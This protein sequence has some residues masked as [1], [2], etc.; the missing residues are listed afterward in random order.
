MSEASE[1]LRE[2]LPLFRAE[3]EE[4]LNSISASL[5]EVEDGPS[6]ERGELV[7]ALLREMHSLKGGARAVN[8]A[9]VEAISHSFETVLVRIQNGELEWSGEVI[10]ACHRTVEALAEL[11]ADDGETNGND[12]RGAADEIAAL[13]DSLDRP[14][15]AKPKKKKKKEKAPAPDL[16]APATEEEQE[17][18]KKLLPIFRSEAEERLESI[19]QALEELRGGA[20]SP[21]RQH[22]LS[23]SVMRDA[24]SIKGGSRTMKLAHVA[25]VC[26]RFEYAAAKLTR[27]EVEPYPELYDLFERA[28]DLVQ[29]LLE[30]PETLN[31]GQINKMIEDLDTI[32]QRA[33]EKVTTPAAPE[34]PVPPVQ[35]SGK[36]AV[37]ARS[38]DTV[39]VATEKLDSVLRHSQEML[40]AK[41]AMQQRNSEVGEIA[42]LLNE[43]QSEWSRV[44]TDVYRLQSWVEKHDEESDSSGVYALAANA[45]RFLDWNQKSIRSLQSQVRELSRRLFEDVQGFSVMVDT[46]VDE[47]KRALML[48]LSTLFNGLPRMV[49]AVARSQ[50][51]AIDFE[52]RGDDV[53]VD[54][55]I[56]D[57]MRDPLMHLLRNC[58]D[59]GI[60]S[61]EEREKDDK[62]KRGQITIEVS[63]AAA[64]E[65]EM[66]VRDDGRG[67]DTDRVRLAAVK[68]GVITESQAGVLGRDEVLQLIFRSGVSTSERVSNISGRGL[69]MAICREGVE[70]LGG[71]IKIESDL[72]RGTAFRIS[73]PL[74]LATYRVL[75]LEAGRQ[76]LAIPTAN[77]ER[78]VR[79][80]PEM[81]TSAN[82][83]DTI[84]V[85]GE[86]V[87]LQHLDR[88]LGH[89]SVRTMEGGRLFAAI[90]RSGSRRVAFA[91]QRVLD[92]QE[93]LFK[94]LGSYLVHVPNVSGA[95]VL[96]TGL[97]VPILNVPEMIDAIYAENVVVTSAA[98]VEAEVE[99]VE[100]RPR[101]ILVVEDSITSRMLL[102]EIL[103]SAG[104]LVSTAIN[105]AEAVNTLEHDE[106]D[107]VVSDVEM[108]RMNGFQLTEHIRADERWAELPVILVTGLERD[109]ERQ[110]G[111]DAGANEYIIKGSF[112]QSNLLEAIRRFCEES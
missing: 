54:K 36:P 33:P 73:L 47:T 83:K 3:S 32:E 104:Y 102:K 23:E 25:A 49:R 67:I 69:G 5:A 100:E 57:E 37:A 106:F 66:L 61:P 94:D 109:E 18:L 8:L 16:D 59:H 103:E 92:E 62:P 68:N 87:L 34:V 11:V 76:T 38:T 60:E 40:I 55:R 80:T 21:E 101:S 45:V 79:L 86:P 71:N 78:V 107:L 85:H 44:D 6:E 10:D 4:R 26:E 81:V 72:G 43:W 74:A 22:E 7:E 89:E 51:K 27:K 31:E 97:V 77:T 64:D 88:Q 42:T 15:S 95:T 90:V 111:L 24:H 58:V 105:G 96:G 35:P 41:L 53:E 46:L 17:L 20:D 50:K 56:L 91:V 99:P 84:T 75:L 112:E 70:R 2:L 48:P 19:G 13:L 29:A 9:S 14:A 110:R 63:Q 28:A 108:P 93:V 65:V 30:S 39:R 52:I 1:V 98:P 12:G 82:G